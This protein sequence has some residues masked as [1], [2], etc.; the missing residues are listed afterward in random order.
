MNDKQLQEKIIIC[1]PTYNEAHNLRQITKAILR[2]LPH[3]FILIIDDNSPDGTGIIANQL[4]EK[5]PNISVLHRFRKEGLGR[6]YI[7]GFR[8]ALDRTDN[9]KLI[10]QMDADFSHS[11]DML[12]NM[13]KAAEKADLVIG[14]RYMAGGSVQNWCVYRRLISQCGSLYARFW[15]G[16][17]TR[18]LTGGFKIWHRDLLEQVLNFPISARGYVFQAETTYIAS[19]LGARITEVPIPFANRNA[20]K[21]KMTADI[22][23]EAFWRLP[24]LRSSKAYPQIN[25]F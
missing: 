15:L 4:A 9:I 12:P 22:A 1:V 21:S 16:M 23:L 8:T 6:A 14:S 3:A 13:V 18:D 10:G 7:N 20:G 17:P 5:N 2:A 19:R 25:F 24:L 11:P